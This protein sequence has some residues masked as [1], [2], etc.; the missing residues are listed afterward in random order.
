MERKSAIGVAVLLAALITLLT[1][2]GA[3]L[4]VR[5][6]SNGPFIVVVVATAAISF[7]SLLVLTQ[8]DKERWELTE[9]SMRTAIAGTIVIVYLV[10]VG[11]V[12]FF[13]H[14]PEKLPAISETMV[15]S[16]TTIVGVVVAFYFGASA[17]VQASS[18]KRERGQASTEGKQ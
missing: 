3:Y 10:L 13:T 5:W 15:T 18:Q 7:V 6:D 1:S 4:S 12:A 9:G 16:F 8:S 17:Y 14:G 11:I 2:L